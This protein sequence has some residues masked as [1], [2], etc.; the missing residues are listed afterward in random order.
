[1]MI[2]RV[3]TLATTLTRFYAANSVRKMVL[4]IPSTM[5]QIVRFRITYPIYDE[6]KLKT[7]VYQML[8]SFIRT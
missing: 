1:M 3:R 5:R 2:H 7:T 8:D 6:Y 4:C